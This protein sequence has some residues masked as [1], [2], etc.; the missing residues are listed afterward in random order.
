MSSTHEGVSCDNC[1]KSNFSG[2]RYK[3]LI[4]YDFDLCSSCYDQSQSQLNPANSTLN[5]DTDSKS[6]KSSKP[7]PISNN[8]QINQS[9]HL[10][11]HA[12]QCI[13][14]R[15]DHEL[16]YGSGGAGIICDFT[17]GG[18]MGNEQQSFTC[19]YCG[20]CGFSESTLCK[21]LSSQHSNTGGAHSTT[22]SSGTASSTGS[23]TRREVVCPICAVLPNSNGGDPN[24][25]TD[26][27]LQHINLEHVI[28]SN[29]NGHKNLDDTLNDIGIGSLNGS[30][31]TNSSNAAAA[32]AAA[33]RFSRRL[34][35]SNNISRSSLASQS[36]ITIG[37][38]SG[39][40][41]NGSSI[42][43]YAFQFGQNNNTGG[44]SNTNALSSFMRSTSSGTGAG[45]D[46][47]GSAL[48]NQ[49][50]PIAELLSQLT[51]VR[52]AVTST[53]STNN[54][55]QQLQQ[56][57]NRERETLQSSSGAGGTGGGNQGSSSSRHHHLNH[58][59]FSGIGLGANL[60]KSQLLNSIASSK[61]NNQNNPNSQ[62][63]ANQAIQ[64]ANSMTSAFSN[65]VLELPPNCL[66]TQSTIPRDPRH[67]LSKY[68]F[69][70]GDNQAQSSDLNQIYQSIFINDILVSILLKQLNT[71]EINTSTLTSSGETS[72]ARTATNSNTNATGN[73]II[74]NNNTEI[75]SN[76]MQMA[77]NNQDE[78]VLA[79]ELLRNPLDSVPE[80]CSGGAGKSK[81]T[82]NAIPSPEETKLMEL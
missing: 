38:S 16:F 67:L 72:E 42:N 60:T 48:S 74:N 17:I 70:N 78:T 12:M 32:A 76:S 81:T 73:N 10:G 58:H 61:S 2:K 51:G 9:S 68:D 4:C 35:Y 45:L 47:L 75:D 56:Q 14:T 64:T 33:L 71:N 3:C 24:H 41:S 21:H 28:N 37:N 23:T 82:V 39:R 36:G 63:A 31:S 13:L 6:K 77:C 7:E 5:Q 29:K 8:I 59:L 80:L 25:L 20:K 55:L 66:F 18:A 65:Q 22:T 54:Q 26:N 50:D 53:H 11:T 30:S 52:R 27:L 69:N 34:N 1:M 15:S 79:E 43:R 46:S 40:M 49:M 62:N 44:H 57:L 19:P